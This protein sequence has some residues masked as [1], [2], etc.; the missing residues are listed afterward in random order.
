ME[1]E[2]ELEKC[3]DWYL[4]SLSDLAN[5]HHD[6]F[7]AIGIGCEVLGEYDSFDEAIQGTER[8]GNERGTFL[9]QK[10]SL[11]PSAY[12]IA[13]YNNYIGVNHYE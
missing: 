2:K 1:N 11:D 7:I 5:K 3:F 4:A 12:S 13:H 6:K 9:V 10:A 8:Q